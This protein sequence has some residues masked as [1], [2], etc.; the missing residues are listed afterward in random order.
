MPIGSGHPYLLGESSESGNTPMAP[1]QFSTTL[2]AIKAQLEAL[3]PVWTQ[4]ETLTETVNQTQHRLGRVETHLENH[5]EREDVKQIAMSV[6]KNVIGWY[7]TI[8]AVSRTLIA[9]T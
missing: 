6:K 2:A 4:L 5:N 9:N 3:I 8:D 1:Q 7:H